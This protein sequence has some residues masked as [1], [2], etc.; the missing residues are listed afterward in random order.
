MKKNLKASWV[1]LLAAGLSTAAN[2]QRGAMRPGS[3][4]SFTNPAQGYP[5]FFDTNLADHGSLVVEWPP[6]ILPI[7]PVP[8]IAVDYGVS[9]TLTVGTNA[10]ISTLP[11][12]FG[13]KGISLKARTLVYGT[14]SAQSVATVYGGYIAGPEFSSSWELFTSNTAYKLAPRH[15]VSG[16]LMFLNLGVELGKESEINYTNIR[17]ST[18]AVGGGYQFLLTDRIAISSYLL[19]ALANSVESD[20]VAANLSADLNVTSG[21]ALWGVARVSADIK[22]GD[23]LYSLGGVYMHGI[24]GK[25]LPWLSATR[26]W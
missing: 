8:S 9:D 5:G 11:W 24:F 6:I 17:F 22:N 19:A 1:L 13:A 16:Q 10:L 7:I 20:T 21:D 15:V 3:P 4:S 26:R 12:L 25:V 2:A 14:D 23:W 18:A